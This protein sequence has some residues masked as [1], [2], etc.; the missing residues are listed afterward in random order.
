M[1]RFKSSERTLVRELAIVACLL[2]CAFSAIADDYQEVNQYTGW[3][4]LQRQVLD[5]TKADDDYILMRDIQ[6]ADSGTLVEIKDGESKTG[7]AIELVIVTYE[8]TN[9]TVL[10]LGVIDQSTG[11]TVMY[12]WAEPG[13]K[14]LGIN[15]RWIQVGLTRM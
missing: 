13:A 3:I 6:F 12:A 15:D 7:Y 10:K 5:E 1:I 9:V 2:I 14:R 8:Q 4:V 11:D